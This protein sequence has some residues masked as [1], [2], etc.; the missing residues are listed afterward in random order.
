MFQ[1]CTL[2]AHTFVPQI[3][4]KDH[5]SSIAILLLNL[6]W[7]N[8]FLPFMKKGHNHST[9]RLFYINPS[10]KRSKFFSRKLLIIKMFIQIDQLYILCEQY[11]CWYLEVIPRE[12]CTYFYICKWESYSIQCF[13]KHGE[14]RFMQ[15]VSKMHGIYDL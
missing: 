2:F 7:M 13:S 1:I 4:W 8:P 3:S 15:D 9:G 6:M 14:N 11:L 5:T 12:I 10:F